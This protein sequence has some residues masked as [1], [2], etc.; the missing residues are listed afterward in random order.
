M[1][2]PSNYS[3]SPGYSEGEGEGHDVD[4]DLDI[5]KAEGDQVV[6]LNYRGLL[7]MPKKLL[8]E[9]PG[10]QNVTRIYMKRNKLT[11][12]VSPPP[13]PVLP[14]SHSYFHVLVFFT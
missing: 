9:A 8:D 7:E 6:H 1:S 14:L 10:F 13:P 5:V 12:L 2:F 11:T 3:S 4:D